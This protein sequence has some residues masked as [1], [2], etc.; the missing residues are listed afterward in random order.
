MSKNNKSI[1]QKLKNLLLYGTTVTD[2][3]RMIFGG[4]TQTYTK[5][6]TESIFYMFLVDQVLIMQ[7]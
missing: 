5:Q 4:H 6:R 1:Y 7:T 2:I 3:Q